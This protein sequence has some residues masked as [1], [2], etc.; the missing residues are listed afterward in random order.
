MFLATQVASQ[1]GTLA[2]VPQVVDAVKVPVIAAGGIADGRGIAAAM[3]LGASGVQCGTTYLFCPEATLSPLHRAALK[4][5]RE[6]ET[7]LT[8]IFTGRPARSIVNRAMRELGLLPSGVPDFPLAS[9]GMRALMLKA[10]AQG[11]REFIALWAGQ[12]ITL[13][14]ELPAR[15]LTLKLAS[16]AL[17]KLGAHRTSSD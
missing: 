6:D 12:G 3:T 4:S 14:S 17:Q 11:S 1:V 5:A 7:A 9:A 10:E 8:T 16:Q 15:D 2:L 13:C